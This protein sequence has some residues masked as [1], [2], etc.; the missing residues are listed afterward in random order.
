MCRTLR[1]LTGA[2]PLFS[3]FRA[4]YLRYASHHE[5]RWCGTGLPRRLLRSTG[6][7]EVV[8]RTDAGL[9]LRGWTTHEVLRFSWPG[10]DVEVRPDLPRADVARR[11]RGPGPTGWEVTLPDTARPLHVEVAGPAGHMRRREIPHPADPRPARARRRLARAFLRDLV[12]AGPALLRYAVRADDGAR[13]AVK[14]AFGLTSAPSMP[15]LDPRWF[16]ERDGTKK[17]SAPPPFTVIVPVHDAYAMTVEALDGLAR[18]T[19]GDWR[20]VIVDDASR[21]P[22]MAPFLREWVAERAGRATL[23]RTGRNLGFVGAVNLGLEHAA[24]HEGHV[25][26]LNSD[27]VVPPGWAPRLLAPLGD[28]AVASATPF[29]NDAEILGAPLPGVPVALP[30]GLGARLDRIAD[31]LAPMAVDLPTGVGFCMALSRHWLDRFPRL[32]PAFGRGYGEEVDWCRKTARAGARHVAVP[33]LFVEHRGGGSFGA[34]KRERVA[35]ANAMISRRYP[36]Y[37]A[38]VEA[39]FRKDPLRT[40]RLALAIATAGFTVRGALPVYLAHS[41]GG[42]AEEALRAE[43][44]GDLRTC[45]AAL[46]L[47][48]GGPARYAV[49]LH[50]PEGRIAAATMNVALLRRLLAP[51]PRL[52]I[53]YSCGVGADDPVGLPDLLL[54]LRRD[55]L[56][57]RLEARLHDYFV[58]SPSYCLLGADQR[59]RG[60]VPADSRDAA[61]QTRRADGHAVSLRCWR[62]AWRRFLSACDSVTVFSGAS[63]DLFIRAYPHLAN[64]VALRPPVAPPLPGF[65]GPPPRPGVI[66]VLGNL[67]AQKGAHVVRDLALRLAAM[68]DPRGIV[69]IGNVDAAFRMPARVAI[70]GGYKRR[71]IAALARRYGVAAWVVPAIWPETYSFA[72]REALA[73]G[74]PVLAFDIGGQGEAVRAAPNGH[75]VP[76]DPDAGLAE[77]LHRALPSPHAAPVSLTPAAPGPFGKVALP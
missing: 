75:P 9:H 39:F 57:D 46:V 27:A 34:E 37:D 16:D 18:N 3:R 1:G 52:R 55:P 68:G 38:E 49:E 71:D 43:V 30:D 65:V 35:V 13:R 56:T 6:Q 47:R 11:H 22:G 7:V 15:H 64:R 63:A 54:S 28:A 60:A 41:L 73:T 12:R 48:V 61:H 32:D 42:G 58:L 19:C 45:G 14:E 31:G 10:G 50:L 23:L 44:E 33:D 77:R 5:A 20:A 59:Y 72:T 25:V 76:F 51:V 21:D 24:R 74:L 8:D 36:G 70:H 17:L 40:P 66:G 26:L 29:S 53:V 2:E 62:S 4:L 69:V 67:N